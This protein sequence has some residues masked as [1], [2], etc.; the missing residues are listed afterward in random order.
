MSSPRRL[1]DA[2]E[3]A[4][5]AQRHDERTPLALLDRLAAD[6]A[7]VRGEVDWSASGK[8]DRDGTSFLHL[9][10]QCAVHVECQRC[11]APFDLPLSVDANLRLARTESEVERAPVDDAECD[12]VLGSHRF[13]L[14]ALLE[15]ELLLAMPYAPKHD[16]CPPASG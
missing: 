12:V 2:F 1:I 15:D 10:A 3:F 7:D 14:L 8:Q 13:D 5:T 16:A 4:R 6:L 9:T 11:G